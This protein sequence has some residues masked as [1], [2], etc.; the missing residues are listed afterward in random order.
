M[1]KRRVNSI[2]FGA[3]MSA[4]MGV[5]LFF[6]RQM[7]GAF[8]LYLFWIIPLMVIVYCT[9]FDVKQGCVLAASMVLL[10]FI[11]ATPVTV[12]YVAASVVAGLVYSYGL[13]KGWSAYQL[14]G[15]VIAISLFIMV[16]TTV[17]MAGVFGYN[18]SE[19]IAFMKETVQKM[20]GFMPQ[21][22]GMVELLTSE[23]LI[24]LMIV[25][26]SVLT[27]I[28]EGVLVH[29]LAFLV[30]RK[31]KMELPPMKPL[32]EITAG[33]GIKIFLML[34]FVALIV[35]LMTPLSQYYEIMMTLFI[36][37]YCI[38]LFYG[39][40]L[41]VILYTAT[42]R[43]NATR[44]LVLMASVLLCVFMPFVAIVLGVIDMFSDMRQNIIKELLSHG[45]KGNN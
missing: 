7:A 25:L 37:A 15:S 29:L 35:M 42:I 31:L 36:I 2:T 40:L 32:G 5:L 12:F 10:S 24:L 18:L 43:S 27:S 26:S 6:N 8:D 19:D 16:V 30:L 4:L 45:N 34:I 9:R 44:S 13:S 28:M 17:L 39:Y 21:S 22:D 3:M 41:M 23:K 38:C 14:I 33:K 11:I 20:L 1:N